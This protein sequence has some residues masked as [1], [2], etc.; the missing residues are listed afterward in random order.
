[1]HLGLFAA[2]M[3]A[4]A[5]YLFVPLLGVA[6]PAV[7]AWKGAGVALLALWAWLAR[8]DRIGRTIALVLALGAAGDILL[9]AVGLEVGAAAF[10]AGHLV[11]I[12]LYLRHRRTPLSA[13][14]RWLAMLLIPLSLIIAAGLLRGQDGL[15]GALLYVAIVA[16]MTAAAWCSRF[17]RYRVGVGAV[18][19]LVS[20]L[21]LFARLAG[22]IEPGVGGV[23]VWS[24]YFGGQALI[25][26]GVVTSAVRP[27]ATER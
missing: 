24:A 25:A 18:L 20:D 4:G 13:S 7:I 5:A 2:A 8:R 3:F 6:G 16:A 19:F 21:I 12:L 23:L 22:H 10:A 26:W 17:S 11:A 27:A 15:A 9:D 14:Q 1:M